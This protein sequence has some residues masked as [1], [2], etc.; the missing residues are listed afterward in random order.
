MLEFAAYWRVV[1]RV[2]VGLFDE[3]AQVEDFAF[4]VADALFVLVVAGALGTAERGLRSL[5]DGVV[6]DGAMGDRLGVDS[7]DVFDLLVYFLLGLS[8]LFIECE[9]FGL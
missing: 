4:E 6:E 7:E 1:L 5:V 2:G 3:T 8:V 9:F